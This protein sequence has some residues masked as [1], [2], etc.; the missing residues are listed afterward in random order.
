MYSYAHERR[1]EFFEAT[2][3]QSSITKLYLKV[4]SLGHNH[5]FGIHSFGIALTI[6]CSNLPISL[7]LPGRSQ[8]SMEY[9]ETLWRR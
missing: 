7:L 9:T 3:A 8:P 5:S 2:R 4:R 6:H 1:A